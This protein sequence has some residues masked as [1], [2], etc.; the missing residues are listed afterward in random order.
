M[1]G[2]EFSAAALKRIAID[3]SLREPHAQSWGITQ[4]QTAILEHG[5][6]D[7][8]VGQEWRLD[9]GVELVL[10]RI[11]GGK[12]QHRGVPAREG[13]VQVGGDPWRR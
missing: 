11:V 10:G 8:E 3:K 1:D 4:P 6:F 7:S 9:V 2:I 5:R 13:G 12:L